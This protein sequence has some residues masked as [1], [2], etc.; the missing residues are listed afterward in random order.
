MKLWFL[1]QQRQGKTDLQRQVREEEAEKKRKEEEKRR[2]EGN[3]AAPE[4]ELTQKEKEA[5][6]KKRKAEAKDKEMAINL[7]MHKDWVL[8]FMQDTGGGRCPWEALIESATTRRGV[9]SDANDEA[10][11]QLRDAQREEKAVER[12]QD[13]EEKDRAAQAVVEAEANAKQVHAN[14]RIWNGVGDTPMYIVVGAVLRHMRSNGHV[15]FKKE[16]DVDTFLIHPDDLQEVIQA[17][18]ELAP[19]S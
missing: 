16:G 6:E 7:D 5:A 4:Q 19:Q 2:Q 13:Q 18:D 8:K 12:S 3:E 1:D 11:R 15:E 14:G 9:V 17:T 10:D